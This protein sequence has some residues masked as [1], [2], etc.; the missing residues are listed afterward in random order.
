[1]A[2]TSATEWRIVGEEVSSCNCDWACPCQFEA[3]P[4]HGNCQTLVAYEIREGHFGD[5]GLDGLRFAE[6]ISFPG[7]VYGGDGTMQLVIDE[8]ATPEQREAIE[9]LV[10]GEHGGSY[11]EVFASM[12]PHRQETV[13]APVE[14]DSDRE[15][16]VA[17]VRL[18]ELAECTIEPIKSPVSGDDHRVRIDMPDGF[19]FKQAEIA[20]AVHT[21]VSG[22]APLAFTLEN[23]YGQL[24]TFDW[25]SD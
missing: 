12:S 23:T 5:T 10:S 6:L 8:A 1:M 21:R 25:S 11:F 2:A 15:R 18:G 4:T 24:N 22:A 16:R 20:N 9:A 7:P 17:A 3:D 14:I 19:E 13:V